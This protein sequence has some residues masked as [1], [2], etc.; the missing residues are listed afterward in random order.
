M[1][2]GTVIILL[3]SAVVGFFIVAGAV[4]VG[5]IGAHGYMERRAAR[6][7]R[8][9]GSLSNRPSQVRARREAERTQAVQV[10]PQNIQGPGPWQ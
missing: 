4:A 5:T 6:Q 10:P 1:E 9:S 8:A 3:V 2:S 7:E